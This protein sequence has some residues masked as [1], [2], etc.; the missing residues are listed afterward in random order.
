MPKSLVNYRVRHAFLV[1]Y[2]LI[3]CTAAVLGASQLQTDPGSITVRFIIFGVIALILM[4]V[5]AIMGAVSKKRSASDIGEW[6]Y[7]K[8]LLSIREYE[9]VLGRHEED[10]KV[11]YDDTSSAGGC[12][13]TISAAYLLYLALGIIPE[14]GI[15]ASFWFTPAATLFIIIGYALLGL[16]SYGIGQHSVTFGVG[17]FFVAPDY[18][19][20]KH[21]KMLEDEEALYVKSLVKIGTQDDLQALFETEWRVYLDGQPDTVY[22]QLK[23]DKA[24]IYDYPYLVGIIVNGPDVV[25]RTENLDIDTRFPGIVE[26][27]SDEGVS[28]LVSRFDIPSDSAELEHEPNITAQEFRKLAKALARRLIKLS[29][30]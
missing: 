20:L 23:V 25:E 2:L 28:V 9:K 24:H 26:Y 4:V 15:D 7:R 3:V 30:E 22:I 5:G 11:F 17:D 8:S 1:S 16:T 18:R 10:F 6:N 13:C 27:M 29:T 12:C 19:G 14:G 21:A